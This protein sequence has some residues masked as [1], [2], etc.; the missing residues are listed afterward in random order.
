[1]ERATGKGR[2]YNRYVYNFYE[3]VWDFK[4]VSLNVI[5]VL[6]KV[7]KIENNGQLRGRQLVNGRG[8]S[9]HALGNWRLLL[10]LRQVGPRTL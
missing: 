3:L 10:S 1:M 5:D 8:Y 7:F 6:Q 9:E 4:F 2:F